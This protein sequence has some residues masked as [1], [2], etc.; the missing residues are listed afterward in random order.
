M[1]FRRQWLAILFALVLGG[2]QLFAATTREDRAYATAINTFQDGNWNRAETQ[3][4]KFIQ[5]K[6]FPGGQLRSPSIICRYAKA[7]GFETTN[8]QSLQPHYAKTLDWWAADLQANKEAAIAL[9]SQD[10]YDMYMHYLTGCADRYRSRKIDVVQIS[11]R[12]N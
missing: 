5:K 7:A 12:R 3:F 6:I 8:I 1:A 11:L 4:A 10:T 2:G 9:T